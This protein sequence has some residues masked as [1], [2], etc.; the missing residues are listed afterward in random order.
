MNV[1]S[2]IESLEKRIKKLKE[3]E[4]LS[5]FN[6]CVIYENERVVIEKKNKQ[7]VFGFKNSVGTPRRELEKR[8]DGTSFVMTNRIFQA[9][10]SKWQGNDGFIHE[11]EDLIQSAN[12]AKE[13]FQNYLTEITDGET[14]D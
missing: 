10:S 2:E 4:R 9:V 12:E 14:H 3:Q 7:Y 5:T 13:F 8:N 11:I 6:D 1:K